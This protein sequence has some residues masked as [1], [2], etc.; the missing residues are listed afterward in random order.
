VI[1][2][3]NRKWSQKFELLH[4]QRENGFE[5]CYSVCQTVR[6]FDSFMVDFCRLLAIL[7]WAWLMV[8]GGGE[9]RTLAA[10]HL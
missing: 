6:L 3:L 2:L 10:L 9:Y 8:V 5:F 4:K 1:K 7:N